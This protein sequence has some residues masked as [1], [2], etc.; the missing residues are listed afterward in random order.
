ML[1]GW[2]AALILGLLFGIGLG[3]CTFAYMAP[4]LGVVLQVAATKL[5]FA[6]ALLAAFGFGHCSVIVLAGTLAEKVQ[7]YLNWTEKTKGA[8]I[9]RKVCGVLVILSGIYLLF[10]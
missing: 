5:V 1:K 10:K 2:Q 8:I 7:Q 6:I 9:L 3:P 4:M